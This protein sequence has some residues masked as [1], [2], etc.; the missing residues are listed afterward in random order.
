MSS[1][2]EFLGKGL[3]YPQMRWPKLY[4]KDS[5][6]SRSVFRFTT[7]VYEKAYRLRDCYSADAILDRQTRKIRALIPYT[8][9]RVPFYRRK[10]NEY[11]INSAT[12][13]SVVDLS[14][15]PVLE[16]KHVRE[17]SE[18]MLAR[19]VSSWRVGWGSTSGSTGIPLEYARDRMSHAA[20]RA[21]YFQLWR[22]ADLNPYELSIL[23]S[24]P[25][26]KRVTPGT[27]IYIHPTQIRSGFEKYIR[28]I[29]ARHPT[30]IRG[31]SLAVLEFAWL[32]ARRYPHEISLRAAILYGQAFTIGMRRF[33]EQTFRCE[34]FSMYALGET[35]AIGAECSFHTGFHMYEDDIFTEIVGRDGHP[36]PDGETGRVVIT[37][38]TNYCMP[39][40]RYDTGDVG[41]LLPELCPCGRKLKLLQFD[42]RREDMLSLPNGTLVVGGVTRRKL[43]QFTHAIERYQIIQ[44]TTDNFEM[45]IVKNSLY[46]PL[47]EA[48]L[49]KELVGLFTR[50]TKM[51]ITCCKEIPLEPSGKIRQF[52]SLVWRQQFPEEF[53]DFPIYQMNV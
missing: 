30:I 47:V 44:H 36:V 6:P 53:F 12:V 17:H 16:R 42:G 37:D 24:A 8:Y 5:E 38:L 4:H 27:I 39:L 7:D 49:R 48:S 13:V 28:E 2:L 19:G 25:N 50:Q 3:L 35:S 15:L 1:V 32:V 34:V 22:W 10:W 18:E 31:A 23:I 46:T 40:I 33:I 43:D 26:H 41:R 14:Q 20:S 45:R 21:R 11:G 29:R 51:S 9:A 52:V